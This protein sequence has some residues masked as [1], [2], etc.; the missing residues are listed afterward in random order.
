MNANTC[1]KQKVPVKPGRYLLEYDYAARD[2]IAFDSCKMGV[3]INNKSVDSITPSDYHVHT[4]RYQFN[5]ESGSPDTIE[6]T[7]CGEGK[8][9]G[10]GAIL[11]NVHVWGLKEC[12]E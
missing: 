5:I 12:Q 1:L 3:Y 10:L 11:N 4:G 7:I 8:S 6:L 2:G 9:D